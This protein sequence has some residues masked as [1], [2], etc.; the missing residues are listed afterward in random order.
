MDW[1]PKGTIDLS[2]TLVEPADGESIELIT[3]VLGTP[4]HLETAEGVIS[5]NILY[6][7]ELDYGTGAYIVAETR[8][9]GVAVDTQT[10]PIG[11]VDIIDLNIR[12][13]IY[14]TYISVYCNNLCVYS[15]ALLSADYT[16]MTALSLERTGSYTV[17]NVSLREI[18]DAREA[19]FVD[20]EATTESAIQS[21]IQQRPIEINPEVDREINFTYDAT[22]DDVPGHNIFSYED[23]EQ[24]NLQLSSDGIVYYEN[25]GVS[26]NADT[27]REVGFITRMYRLSELSNGAIE[28][29]AKYQRSALQRRHLSSIVMQRL[30]PRI[31]VRDVILVDVV[32]TG[33]GRHITDEVIVEDISISVEDGNYS[34]NISGRRNG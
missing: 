3:D 10:V 22:K 7:A 32:V 29:A 16:S 12:I 28:A 33:T 11:L 13:F 23:N 4:Q 14:D 26:I 19:V 24:D 17:E 6:E 15:Y 21:V 31:E 25:V 2:F 8:I 27:A 18:P 5:V 9:G 30:D 1:Q 34:T 20:Y